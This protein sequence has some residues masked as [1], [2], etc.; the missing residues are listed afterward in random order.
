MKPSVK[1]GLYLGGILAAIPLLFFVLNL[2]KEESVQPVSFLLNLIAVTSMIVL[3][4][5]EVRATTNGFISFGKAFSTG[6]VVTLI[7][8]VISALFT[9]LYFTV[10]NKGM[11]S[12]IKMKQEEEM[13]AKGMTEADI[14]KYSGT[15]EFF[16]SP[17]MMTIFAFLI[18]FLIGLVVALICAAIMKKDDPSAQ[19]S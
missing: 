3:A 11:V 5:K 4:I 18:M 12:H 2:D 6:L 15:M 13:L 17:M 9:Y 7:S 19:I 10:I 1:Y 8:S 16:T 14:E